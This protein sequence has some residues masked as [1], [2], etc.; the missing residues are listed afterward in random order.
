MLQV[1]WQEG[2]DVYLDEIHP[3]IELGGE[4][5]SY[6]HVYKTMFIDAYK[7]EMDDWIIEKRDFIYYLKGEL[8]E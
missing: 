5:F 6:S 8:D 2:F 1:L 4:T 3:D 7:E